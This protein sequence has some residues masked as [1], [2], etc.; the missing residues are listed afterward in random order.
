MWVGNMGRLKYEDWV[1]EEDR[2]SFPRIEQTI[3]ELQNNPVCREASSSLFWQIFLGLEELSAVLE[4]ERQAQ[5]MEKAGYSFSEALNALAVED[6]IDKNAVLVALVRRNKDWQSL[7]P[8]WVQF[9]WICLDYTA[10]DR[11]YNILRETN[12]ESVIS[13]R[14][15]GQDMLLSAALSQLHLSTALLRAIGKVS[16]GSP[17]VVDDLISLGEKAFRHIWEHPELYGGPV[18]S[19]RQALQ[20]L[21]KAGYHVVPITP[22]ERDMT[23]F[24]ERLKSPLQEQRE[25][26]LS[27]VM[28]LFLNEH[29]KANRKR[30]RNEDAL[31]S[32]ARAVALWAR[33]TSCLEGEISLQAGVDCCENLFLNKSAVG[34]WESVANACCLIL[35]NLSE[36]PDTNDLFALQDVLD[37]QGW[38]WWAISYWQRAS[39]RAENEMS[40]SQFKQLQGSCETPDFVVAVIWQDSDNGQP[41]LDQIIFDSNLSLQVFF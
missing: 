39:T 9:P 41:R 19:E 15:G 29:F 12:R 38:S 22:E 32:F 27:A 4:I 26:S 24:V 34:D 35:D 25:Q 5:A 13:I 18:L 8:S 10:L 1:P 36:F 21:E 28:S 37:K 17:E 6:N 3:T 2:N 7:P 31:S 33:S 16:W 30:G 40:P 20:L 23:S 11:I 14:E